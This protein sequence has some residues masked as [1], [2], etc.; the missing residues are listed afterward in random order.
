MNRAIFVYLE[1]NT[2]SYIKRISDT[3]KNLNVSVFRYEQACLYYW[4]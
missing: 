1:L 3:E 4:K 2:Q